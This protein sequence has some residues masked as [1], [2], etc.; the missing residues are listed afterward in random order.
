VLAEEMAGLPILNHNGLHMLGP[1][2]MIYGTEEQKR[3][4]LPPIARAEAMW[5]QGYSE[6]DS[7]SDLASLK[8]RAVRAGDEYVLNG[9]KIWT[10]HG[11]H[12][13]W[14]FVLARTDPAA[15]KHRG[16]SFFLVP[17]RSPGLRVLPLRSMTGYVTFC[18]EF[19]DDVHVPAANVV[20]PENHGWYV[21]AA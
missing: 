17:M 5:A 8:T 4:H 10:G 21:G 11:E 15:P 3:E 14:I 18:Q 12:A 6:P 16:I 7:G 19:F 1:I 9:T 20:G 13:D 2:L